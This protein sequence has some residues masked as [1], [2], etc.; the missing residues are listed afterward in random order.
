MKDLLCPICGL[1]GK[2][3]VNILWRCPSAMDIWGKSSEA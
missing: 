2:S 1:E 3:V